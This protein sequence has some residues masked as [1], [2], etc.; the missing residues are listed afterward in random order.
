MVVFLKILDRFGNP[1]G[2]ADE[3][4]VAGGEHIRN[5]KEVDEQLDQAA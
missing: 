5:G 3:A 1:E 4:E 2:E